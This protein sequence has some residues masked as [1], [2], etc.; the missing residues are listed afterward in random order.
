MKNYHLANA[1][2]VNEG[3]IFTGDLIIKDGYIYEVIRGGRPASG[4][5]D[6]IDL[7]G[8]LIL[9]GVIDDHVHFREPGLTYKADLLSESRAAVAGGVTSFMDMPNTLPPV[10][11]QNILE[12]KY[13]LASQKSLANYSFYMGSSNDNLDD[14]LRTDPLK[15]CGIKVF[16]GSSTGNLLLDDQHTLEMIFSRSPLL[17]AVHAEDDRIISENLRFFKEKYNDALSP[18]MHPLIRNAECCYQASLLAVSLAREYNTRLHILHLST[19]KELQL[20][21]KD[22][23]LDQKM[24][25][26]EVCV[27]Y[28]WFSDR[29]YREYGNRIKW[30]PAIKSEDDRRAL[31]QGLFDNSLD[32]IA[33]DHSPHT[34]EEKNR[35]YLQAPSGA[36]FI[37]HALIV[38]LEFHH[39]GRISLERIVDMMCHRPAVCFTIRDRGFIREGYKA[40][41]TVIDTNCEWTIDHGNLL[42]KCGWS[43]LEGTRFHSMITHTFVNGHLVYCDGR[44]DES[45]KG[46]RLLFSR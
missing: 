22:I 6:I 37:Q 29:N 43:P 31:F 7:S 5:A 12:E 32:V 4:M 21:D 33:T 28:L 26:S 44:F 10:L 34:L 13:T 39:Q 9:P 19:E 24:I 15:V 11:T 1:Q 20:L 36:P 30:N 40:D 18:D 25:T 38:M 27:H 8:K 45:L 41:L 16:I 2:I 35:P 42:Y 23:P 17:I 14:V 3:E 46:E